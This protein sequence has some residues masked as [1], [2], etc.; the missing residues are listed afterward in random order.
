VSFSVLGMQIRIKKAREVAEVL[1][2]ELAAREE[3][4]RDTRTYRCSHCGE[5]GHNTR[6]CAVYK[7]EVDRLQ[8]R[9]QELELE[10]ADA[11]AQLSEAN[12]LV[13]YQR[14][15]LDELRREVV[16]LKGLLGAIAVYPEGRRIYAADASA[17]V[18]GDTVVVA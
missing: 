9:V 3:R 15:E 18:H 14:S 6:T 1:G 13:N 2:G 17:I 10:L 16:G 11:E 7:Q 8:E 5:Q 4:P 12:T